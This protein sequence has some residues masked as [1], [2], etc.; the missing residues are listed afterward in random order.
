M[1]VTLKM[2]GLNIHMSKQIDDQKY[3]EFK[4]STEATLKSILIEI[5]ELRLDLKE[6]TEDHNNRITT[7]ESFKYY[8]IGISAGIGFLTAYFKDAILKRL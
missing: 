6:V 7:L 1:F 2:N 8:L 5:K 3:G 4:G